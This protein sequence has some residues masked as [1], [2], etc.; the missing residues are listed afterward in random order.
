MSEVSDD[1]IRLFPSF[2]MFKDSF[3][4]FSSH[5][6]LADS[7][8]TP[9]RTLLK[10]VGLILDALS[11]LQMSQQNTA[12]DAPPVFPCSLSIF[13][14]IKQILQTAGLC[15]HIEPPGEYTE[16]TSPPTPTPTRKPNLIAQ[17]HLEYFLYSIDILI[18]LARFKLE[19][20]N[21]FS[22]TR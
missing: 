10:W 18:M 1:L 8:C 22:H 20:C 17:S 5:L 16:Y 9:R 13:V 6:L 4:T 15:Q 11:H 19:N 21:V 2:P 12:P 3:N 7:E 14:F